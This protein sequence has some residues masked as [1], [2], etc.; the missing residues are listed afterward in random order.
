MVDAELGARAAEPGHHLVDDQQD[1]ELV[2]AERAHA[3]QIAVR[4]HDRRRPLEPGHR[5]DHDVAAIVS[6]P[7]APIASPASPRR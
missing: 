3:F 2:R 1:A 5:L 7:A 6:G 4:R